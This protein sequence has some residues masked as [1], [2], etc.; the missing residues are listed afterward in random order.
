ML[1]HSLIH[2]NQFMTSSSIATYKL[3]KDSGSMIPGYEKYMELREYARVRDFL[4]RNSI[5][6]HVSEPYMRAYNNNGFAISKY[7]NIVLP[8]PE[9]E[10]ER[11]F[12]CTALI[13]GCTITSW[14]KVWKSYNPVHC[15]SPKCHNDPHHCNYD[16]D[17]ILTYWCPVCDTHTHSMLKCADKC[18]NCLIHRP[19]CIRLEDDVNC[20]AKSCEYD[21]HH[22]NPRKINH[23]YCSKCHQCHDKLLIFCD[24]CNDCYLAK[25]PHCFNNGCKDNSHHD[26]ME[27]YCKECEKCLSK[28]STHCNSYE[29][30]KDPHH[31][32][33]K[34]NFVKCNL[35]NECHYRR[36]QDHIIL[37]NVI[38][39][40]ISDYVLDN[41]DN[42]SKYEQNFYANMMYCE[43]CKK[44]QY[45]YHCKSA[46]CQSDPHHERISKINYCYCIKCKKC[47][48]D[49][50]CHVC[51]SHS[52]SYDESERLMYC[53]KCAFYEYKKK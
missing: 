35:C 2:H 16:K 44:C 33:E 14:D 37:P 42:C 46:D 17:K 41:L 21:P 32:D 7:C 25:K 3:L 20:I 36:L 18:N 30:K 23:G 13:P 15:M 8:T 26:V 27:Y 53:W 28:E 50:Y 5:H 24:Q 40:I 19:D 29:C 31:L 4:S 51:E 1:V 6:Y 9:N 39:R 49:L 47:H 43:I 48:L 11:E 12:V 10:Y 45:N 52:C 22:H 34:Y 38:I